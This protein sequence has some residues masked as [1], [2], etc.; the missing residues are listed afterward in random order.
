MIKKRAHVNSNNIFNK[1][2]YYTILT[3]YKT[4]PILEPTSNIC[5]PSKSLGSRTLN[6]YCNACLD[7]E[8]DIKI[9]SCKFNFINVVTNKGR[10]LTLVVNR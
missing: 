9:K 4:A 6:T 1:F 3:A 8:C 2:G 10:G 7:I 5:F